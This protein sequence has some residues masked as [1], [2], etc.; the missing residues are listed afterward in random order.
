[1]YPLFVSAPRKFLQLREKIS[2]NGFVQLRKQDQAAT[3]TCTALAA[4]S[5][6]GVR[7]LPDAA[8][9]QVSSS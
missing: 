4:K 2:G 3:M 6:R 7:Q 1:L 9:I 5:K 8:L